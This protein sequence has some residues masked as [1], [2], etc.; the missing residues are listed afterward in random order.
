ME[1]H[2]QHIHSSR[3]MVESCSSNCLEKLLELILC[4]SLHK[5]THHERTGDVLRINTTSLDL[6]LDPIHG[7][8]TR[9]KPNCREHYGFSCHSM[10]TGQLVKAAFC[11]FP[12]SLSPAN[13]VGRESLSRLGSFSKRFHAF[14]EN[15]SCINFPEKVKKSTASWGRG[16]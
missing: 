11:C 7:C 16:R 3:S 15:Q 2:T 10:R 12:V 14:T 9:S 1:P 5:L 13:P 4:Q 8:L 6:C